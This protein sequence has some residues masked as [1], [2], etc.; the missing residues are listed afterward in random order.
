MVDKYECT[1]HVIQTLL[2]LLVLLLLLLL[3]T[4]THIHAHAETDFHN[5][6]ILHPKL[7]THA[8][9]TFI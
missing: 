7:Q 1:K 5:M 8:L 9:I 6:Y 4:H 2:L 3:H